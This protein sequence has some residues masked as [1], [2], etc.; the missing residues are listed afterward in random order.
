MCIRDRNKYWFL[1]KILK[2]KIPFNSCI[3]PT[4]IYGSQTWAL[5]ERNKN[6]L[7]VTQNKM[8]KGIMGISQ[9]KKIRVEKAKRL[10]KGNRNAVEE[11]LYR[12]R[13]WAE[14]LSRRGGQNWVEK[15]TFWYLRQEKRNRGRQ[16]I[17]WTDDFA[18]LLTHKM[19]H[20][21]TRCKPEWYRLRSA[22]AYK[23][24]K[25]S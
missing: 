5:R 7:Q 1:K 24:D 18:D 4:M 15:T 21:V 19:L 12:K 3:I 11:S 6:K 16:K 23:G 9:N 2:T 13:D 22:F 14:H 20:Q 17:S 25:Y 10:L 8:E